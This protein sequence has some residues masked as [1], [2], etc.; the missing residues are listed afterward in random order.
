[1][2]RLKQKDEDGG[3]VIYMESGLCKWAWDK[4]V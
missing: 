1:M 3:T 4:G 2:A